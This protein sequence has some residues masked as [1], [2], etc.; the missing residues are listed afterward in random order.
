MKA[1]LCIAICMITASAS[2]VIINVPA[3]HPT[4]QEAIDAAFDGD[5]ILVEP[6]VY[7]GENNFNGKSIIVAS[8]YG[9]E[10]CIIDGHKQ[11][12]YG[13]RFKSGETSSS[14][15]A[16]FTIANCIS[17]VSQGTGAIQISNSSPRIFNCV[18][19]N[20]TGINNVFSDGT[21]P[22]G[23]IYLENSNAVLMNCLI[24]HNHGECNIMWNYVFATGGMVCESSSPVIINC[25]IA[26]NSCLNIESGRAGGLICLDN[27]SPIIRNTIIQQNHHPEFV[28]YYSTPDV[29]YS[30]I[31]SYSGGTA[32]IDADPMFLTGPHGDYY[33]ESIAAGQPASS[34]C[35]NT[36]NAAASDTCFDTTEEI[37]CMSMYTVQT[38]EELD[39]GTV[40]MGYHYGKT[41]S[42]IGIR[43][44]MSTTWLV[45]G[46]GLTV[47]ACVYN[48]FTPLTQ[49]PLFVILDAG[50]MLF[51][52]DSWS[53]TPDYRII[54]VPTGIT[55]VPIIEGLTW[56]DTGT[57]TISNLVFWSAMT[58]A[59]MS[60]ILGGMDG[61]SRCQFGYGPN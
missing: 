60:T 25:T 49:I 22:A 1:I 35:L 2:A 46:D 59:T 45:S 11:Q 21:S 50:G 16:G 44:D 27:S 48:R 3:D 14:L 51:F 57:S 53:T 20:N 10:T 7:S 17:T 5:I 40:D 32:N 61:L 30:N 15:L 52:W 56:P 26:D 19:R 42:G 37:A 18:V 29:Q 34:P 55:I 13:F 23:G 41:P 8:S 33:L 24:E 28:S 31:G 43:I 9:P 12:P 38:N 58:D 36:G 39:S 4:I 6:G 47:N 54:D